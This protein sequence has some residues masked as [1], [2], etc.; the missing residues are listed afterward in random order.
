MTS[1]TDHLGVDQAQAVLRRVVLVATHPIGDV[2]HA[3]GTIVDSHRTQKLAVPGR[4]V[5][6]RA[7]VHEIADL[8]LRS[9]HSALRV[10]RLDAVSVASGAPGVQA[11]E[12]DHERVA[13]GPF[14]GDVE[15]LGRD[16][17]PGLL[18]RHAERAGDI[19]AVYAGEAGPGGPSQKGRAAGRE[20]SLDLARKSGA[21]ERDVA[22][23]AERVL[24]DVTEV[25]K[26]SQRGLLI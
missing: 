8:C 3:A 10:G 17:P 16:V 25:A 21:G 5:C 18:D 11:H 7:G 13:A 26:V 1:L 6:N 14:D 19:S 2:A 4:Q 15:S 9:G 20:H 22:S 24:Y 12:L 23:F